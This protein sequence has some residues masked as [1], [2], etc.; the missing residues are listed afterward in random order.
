MTERNQAFVILTPGFA[1]SETDS[2]CLPMQQRFVRT[3]REIHPQ[4]SIFILA[5]QYP[6]RE[7][8]YQWEKL[9]VMAFNGR[10]RGGIQRLLLQPRLFNSLK[11]I[12]E[13]HH[14]VGLLSFW[15]GECALVG[16]RFSK[17]Y[18]LQ[19]QCWI[20]GQDARK[21]NH[22]PAKLQLK[23]EHLVALSDFLQEEFQR[24]HG[25]RPGNVIAPGIDAV[26]L[27]D[28]S[29]QRDIDILNVGSLIALKQFEILIEIVDRLRNKFPAIRAVLAGEGPEREKLEKLV[30]EKNLENHLQLTGELSYGEV[31]QLMKRSKIL[32]HPSSYEGFSGVCQEA[33]AAGAEVISF[34]RAMNHEI[35]HWHIVSSKE[36]MILKVIDLLSEVAHQAKPVLTFS[37]NDTV[38]KMLA[39][40]R[41]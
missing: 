6:F 21:Q 36:E 17:K 5:F 30:R 31:L 26:D 20:L 28:A 34:C 13:S 25:T 11:K 22:Y 35:E 27:M 40:Y 29:D 33:L 2:A 15:Y 8:T 7:E 32:L 10:N 39:L 38:K 1:S 18:G 14:I 23:S 16:K 37:M 19:H 41:L 9:T 12:K 24:N 4:L 3:L